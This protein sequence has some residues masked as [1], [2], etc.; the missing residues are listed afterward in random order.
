[1]VVNEESNICMSMG[2]RF[3]N[4]VSQNKGVKL[5]SKF[6]SLLFY[7][8]RAGSLKVLLDRVEIWSSED[9]PKSLTY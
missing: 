4:I 6:V 8:F 2:I 9:L 3:T 7:F 1:M 5:K